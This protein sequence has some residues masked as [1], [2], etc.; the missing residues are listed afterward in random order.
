VLAGTANVLGENPLLALLVRPTVLRQERAARE[1]A[2]H[3]LA[4][5]GMADRI[6]SSCDMLSVGQMKRV[7]V[8]R[9]LQM[10]ASLLL[11]D[12]PFAGLDAA[13]VELFARDLDHLRSKHAKTILVVEHRHDSLLP[14]ADRVWNM[15]DGRLEDGGVSRG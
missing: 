2:L 9:L 8:A 3:N 7:A 12:E 15:N 13:S 6:Q 11:L 4:L 14:I 10:E 1:R 5:V